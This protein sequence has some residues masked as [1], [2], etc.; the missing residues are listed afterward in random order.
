MSPQP[1]D[2]FFKAVHDCCHRLQCHTG[3]CS[4]CR[5]RGVLEPLA[6]NRDRQTRPL[7][8]EATLLSLLPP[9]QAVNKKNQT[10]PNKHTQL[11]PQPCPSRCPGDT[12][13]PLSPSPSACPHPGRPRSPR[14]AHAKPAPHQA[15]Q[16]AP[17]EAQAAFP[18]LTAGRG[19]YPRTRRFVGSTHPKVGPQPGGLGDA[20]ELGI[21][22]RF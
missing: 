22:Q 13:A 16:G 11:P 19:G 9:L 4:S 20:L 1:V 15:R 5:T 7:L 18:R 21:F 17:R 2:L 14:G 3:T 10:K 8:P 6:L 12:G